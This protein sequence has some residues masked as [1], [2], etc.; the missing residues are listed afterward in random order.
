MFVASWQAESL[1]LRPIPESENKNPT[2]QK[3]TDEQHLGI[4]PVLLPGVYLAIVEN[5]RRAGTDPRDFFMRANNRQTMSM[6]Q[7]DA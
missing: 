1:D 6:Y 3:K 2:D 5:I 7:A 4:L